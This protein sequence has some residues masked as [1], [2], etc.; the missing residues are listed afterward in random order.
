MHFPSSVGEEQTVIRYIGLKGEST[1]VTPID[2]ASFP[3]SLFMT[4]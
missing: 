4:S 1:K 3:L 2:D